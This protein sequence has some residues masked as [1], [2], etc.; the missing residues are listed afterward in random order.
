MINLYIELLKFISATNSDQQ[1]SQLFNEKSV[2][3]DELSLDSF[4]QFEDCSSSSYS[5]NAFE[6]V[7]EFDNQI[8]T[9]E[10]LKSDDHV[11][12]FYMKK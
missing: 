12:N 8:D 4:T 3:V 9:N 10:F 2:Y 11:I 5:E 7:I 1:S 6:S